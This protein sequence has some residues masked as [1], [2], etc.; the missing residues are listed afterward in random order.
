MTKGGSRYEYGPGYAQSG[1]YGLS[2]HRDEYINPSQYQ[3]RF[4][5][6]E[7]CLGGSDVRLP[8]FGALDK[9]AQQG[10]GPSTSGRDTAGRVPENQKTHH[11]KAQSES[12]SKDSRAERD[13]QGKNPILQ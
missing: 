5:V 7:P 9:L 4:E 12:R 11:M 13:T 2:H 6:L 3:N 1:G 8:G 10:I